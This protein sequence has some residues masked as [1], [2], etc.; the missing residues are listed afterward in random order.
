MA[1][2]GRGT[3]LVTPYKRKRDEPEAAAPA[4]W[5]RFASSLRQ[6]LESLFGWLIQR[7]NIQNAV[8][9]RST[10]GSFVYVYGKLAVAFAVAQH[11]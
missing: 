10:E 8:P 2:A 1:P 9:A 11:L 6:P 4:P 5:S 7:T 3:H